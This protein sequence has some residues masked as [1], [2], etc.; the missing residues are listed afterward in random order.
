V[1]AAL[2]VSTAGAGAAQNAAQ[3]PAGQQPPVTG[4]GAVPTT[5]GAVAPAAPT[6]AVLTRSFTAPVGLVFNT[7]RPERVEQF[8]RL[9]AEVQTALAASKNPTTQ[10]QAKGW[11][12]YKVGEAGPGGVILFVFVID[13]VVAGEDYSL[14]KVLVEAFPDP[15]KLQEVWAL[16]TGSVTGGGSLLNLTPVSATVVPATKPA[17]AP[18]TV[19]APGAPAPAPPL[20]PR[21][22]PD[23]DPT[24]TPR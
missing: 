22:P 10:A 12:F 7:V 23:S 19:P 5:P 16:Y 9:L 20:V 17:A 8:E 11:R 13:P 3:T 21:A 4:R 24:R 1:I 15:V 18:A 2:A 14:G 6:T